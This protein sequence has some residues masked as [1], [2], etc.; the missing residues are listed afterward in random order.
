MTHFKGT[1]TGANGGLMHLSVVGPENFHFDKNYTQ[2]FD[3]PIKLS[4]GSY[5]VSIQAASPG[6]FV[7]DVVDG[8][9]SIDPEVPDSFNKSIHVYELQV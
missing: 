2:S 1:I 5:I 3:E 4:E 6:K 8:Y 7:F 9:K